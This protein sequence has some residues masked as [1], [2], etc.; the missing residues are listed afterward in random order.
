MKEMTAEKAAVTLPDGRPCPALMTEAE[1]VQFLRI[2]EVSK[3]S[4]YHNVIEHLKRV[5]GFPRIRICGKPLYPL[6]A[7]L[8]WINKQAERVS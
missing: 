7:V 3:A 2:P 1:V 8:E 6:A 5:R 4:D